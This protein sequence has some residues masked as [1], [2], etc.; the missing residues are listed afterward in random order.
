MVV[1]SLSVS[2]DV[3]VSPPPDTV[4]VLVTLAGALPATFTVR[5]MVELL[6]AA[7]ALDRVQVRATTLQ[8]QPEPLMA[9]AVKPEGRV[10]VTVMVPLVDGVPLLVTVI[11]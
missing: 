6:P 7:S 1:G 3:S 10:S 4:A 9:V 5:V 8:V 2:L 11:V